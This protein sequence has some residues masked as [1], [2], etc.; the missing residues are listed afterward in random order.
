MTPEPNPCPDMDQ[1]K[2][3]LHTPTQVFVFEFHEPTAEDMAR[4]RYGRPDR[5]HLLKPQD[6]K[7]ADNR[8]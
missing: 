7:P 6:S 4:P 2:T 8:K 1:S 3:F 5:S